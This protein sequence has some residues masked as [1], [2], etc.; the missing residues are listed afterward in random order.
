MKLKKLMTLFAAGLLMLFLSCENMLD[1]DTAPEGT[2]NVS[3]SFP[4]I[5]PSL[6]TSLASTK[7]DRD[8]AYL[9]VKYAEVTITDS[10]GSL[11][12][13]QTLDSNTMETEDFGDNLEVSFYIPW[14]SGYS[15]TVE[16]FD[17]ENG[18]V[19]VSGSSSFSVGLESVS[20]IL[21]LVP[22]NTQEL[23]SSLAYSG[24][25]AVSIVSED[26]STVT[27]LGGEKWFSYEAAEG[28]TLLI[29]LKSDTVSSMGAM[30]MADDR[31]Y[32]M[33][34]GFVSSLQPE[35]PSHISAAI[36]EAGIY[37]FGMG[38]YDKT[39]D[40]YDDDYTIVIAPQTGTVV[41]MEAEDDRNLVEAPLYALIMDD[42]DNWETDEPAA[43]M[44]GNLDEGMDL[45]GVAE[46]GDGGYDIWEASAGIYDIYVY[47]DLDGSGDISEGDYTF[48][49]EDLSLSGSSTVEELDLDTSSM[50]LE[51]ADGF[52]GIIDFS[53]VSDD[54][55]LID[56]GTIKVTVPFST[57][58]S[59]LVPSLISYA[60][61]SISPDESTALDFS[62]PVVYT[63]TGEDS[64]EVS[65]TVTVVREQLIDEDLT[66]SW[67]AMNGARPASLALSTDGTYQAEFFYGGSDMSLT[68]IYSAAGGTISFWDDG[69]DI[70]MIGTYSYSCGDGTL[71]FS[72]IDE[73]N[74]GR[75]GILTLSWSDEA[76]LFYSLSGTITLPAAVTDIPFIVALGKDLEN[77]TED[78]RIDVVGIVSDSSF[79][80][81]LENVAAGTYFLVAIVDNDDS[82]DLTGEEGITDGDY[83]YVLGMDENGFPE[84]PNLTILGDRSQDM[85]LVTYEEAETYTVSG[86]VTLPEEVADKGYVICLDTNLDGDDG[87]AY[88]VSDTVTGSTISYTLTGVAAGD[89]YL[90]A[91]VDLD[92]SGSGISSG[93]YFMCYGM[94]DSDP[95]TADVINVAGDLSLDMTL[96]TYTGESIGG[97]AH[98]NDVSSA[99]SAVEAV[100]ADITPSYNDDFT[101]AYWVF[102]GTDDTTGITLAGTLSSPVSGGE[103]SGT[104]AVSGCNVTGMEFNNVS[105][106]GSSG[107]VYF[108]FSDDPGVMYTYDF[109]D[110]SLVSE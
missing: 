80:Y 100:M 65:Y 69:A 81:T 97:D 86:T 89:Y 54:S 34:D 68:G 99:F 16:I 8:R 30:I 66:G 51:T 24:T 19:L 107:T 85:T 92:N 59:S 78:Y 46:D 94:E 53:L 64:S 21:A 10:E 109:S 38:L 77:L 102:D 70:S 61:T 44:F 32:S 74:S 71:S 106:E 58:L 22:Q 40:P 43:Y 31:G 49:F 83:Y 20:V 108:Y 23:T 45:F 17:G 11:V 55:A 88:Y 7:G 36:D 57:D 50:E 48:C 96:E 9:Y 110:S 2:G 60:G 98:Y 105:S 35:I 29:Q 33:G 37:Y 6:M 56:D 27:T 39:V 75:E 14:G 91:M 25:M 95:G 76:P 13:Y 67:Y 73:P 90:Y 72:A 41:K 84:T 47:V 87:F 103:I 4:R 104:L 1:I 93:D 28:E 26:L 15:V 5:N 62:S 52:T 18:T 82:W 12:A 101:I 79:S 3:I 42:G 63:V